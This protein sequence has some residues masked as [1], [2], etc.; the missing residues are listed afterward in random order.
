MDDKK[1]QKA[2]T[3]EINK[4]VREIND[5]YYR[6]GYSHH[7]MPMPLNQTYLFDYSIVCHF[8]PVTCKT[9]EIACF[10]HNDAL[11]RMKNLLLKGV[12]AWIKQE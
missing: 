12:C 7:G 5:A 4:Y 10:D 11:S 1:V 8:D 6:D 9:V 3:A 2:R